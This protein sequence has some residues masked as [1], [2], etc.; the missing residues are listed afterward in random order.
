MS[1]KF[2][3]FGAAVVAASF[4]FSAGWVEPVGLGFSLACCDPEAYFE[5]RVDARPDPPAWALREPGV[6]EDVC[7]SL[8]YSNAREIEITALDEDVVWATIERAV[9]MP[10]SDGLV[11]SMVEMQWTAVRVRMPEPG[12]ID[13][14]LHGGGFLGTRVVQHRGSDWALG[15]PTSHIVAPLHLTA[16]NGHFVASVTVSIFWDL[17]TRHALGREMLAGAI[18]R[19]LR[20]PGWKIS[21]DSETPDGE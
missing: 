13:V 8:G 20:R 14:R 15:P 18:D 21:F 5:E 17:W 1:G 11:K 12:P 3:A 6:P 9:E 10:C 7:V 4:A 2:L 16:T 19:V